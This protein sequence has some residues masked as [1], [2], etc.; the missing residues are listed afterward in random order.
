MIKI[1]SLSSSS[2]RR[3]AVVA[4]AEQQPKRSSPPPPPSSTVNAQL[5]MSRIGKA[6]AEFKT[7]LAQKKRMAE[8]QHVQNLRA[9]TKSLGDCVEDMKKMEVAF[10]SALFDAIIPES[11]PQGS[12]S[13]ASS[14]EQ[15]AKKTNS[16]PKA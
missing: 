14:G 13:A 1:T 5:Y 7:T 8:Q 3:V 6:H 2:S 9:F 12:S 15:D 10:A 11:S 16:A 4:R